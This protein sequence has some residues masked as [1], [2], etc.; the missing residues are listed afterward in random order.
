MRSEALE[1]AGFFNR[2]SLGYFVFVILALW[3]IARITWVEDTGASAWNYAVSLLIEI[4]LIS[5]YRLRMIDLEMDYVVVVPGRFYFV[6]QTGVRLN[7]QTLR[8]VT[9]I[10]VVR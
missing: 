10:L 6:D 1:F 2:V 7:E 5:H 9:G 3:E 8:L 4:F